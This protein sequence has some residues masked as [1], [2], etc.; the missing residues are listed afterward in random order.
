MNA[1]TPQVYPNIALIQQMVQNM[2][3]MYEAMQ[4]NQ[5]PDQGRGREG[6]ETNDTTMVKTD[7]VK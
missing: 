4:H 6:E 2:Q 3:V 5:G 7:G 1:V